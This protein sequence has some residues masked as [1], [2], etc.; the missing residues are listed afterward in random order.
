MLETDHGM[1][2]AEKPWYFQQTVSRD[3]FR[4][5]SFPLLKI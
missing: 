4:H 2:I 5:N 1:V 3:G